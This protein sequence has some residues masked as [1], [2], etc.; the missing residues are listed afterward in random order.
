ML[1]D[2]FPASFALALAAK[3]ARLVTEAAERHGANTPVANTIAD[4]FTKGVEAG[5][6]APARPRPSSP[7]S[8]VSVGRRYRRRR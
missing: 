5:Y 4:R 6:Q 8:Y 2:E 7:R 1:D 3:D